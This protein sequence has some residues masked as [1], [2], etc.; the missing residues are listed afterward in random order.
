MPQQN[1]LPMLTA[2][3][4]R[5]TLKLAD[6]PRDWVTAASLA[7]AIGVSRRTVLREL[8]G[9][10]QWM[11]A[12]G[13]K[14]V[15]SPGQGIL[16]EESE[17]RRAELRR[18]AAAGS[19]G[20]ALPREERR[21]RLLCTLLAAEEP[22]K[23][24]A[25]AYDLQV[26]EHTLAADLAWAEEWLRPHGTALRRRPGVGVWVE[27]APQAKRRAVGAL[28][29][30]RLPEQNRRAFLRGEAPEEP[31]TALFDRQ[32]AAAVWAAL[33]EFEK[34]EKLEFTDAGFLSLAVHCVLTVEQLGAGRW[35]TESE[36]GLPD[37]QRPAA[38]QQAARLAQKL[39]RAFGV[40]IPPAEVRHLALYLDVY[41]GLSDPQEWGTA[42]E[43]EL[44]SLAAALIAGVEREMGVDLGRYPTL[45][46]DLY[47]HLRPMFYRVQQGAAVENPQL[48]LIQQQYAPLWR[49][50]RAA[51]DE[52]AG[53]LGLP[54]IPDAE[55][56][57]LAMHFGAVLEKESIARMRV[58]A[59]VV[60]PY[61]M[62]SSKFLASQLLREF[63]VLHITASC[64]ARELDPEA[65]RE[66][67]VDVV[68]STVP[69]E[70]EFPKVCVNPI[71]QEQDRAQLRR[72]VEQAQ[73]RPLRSGPQ[74]AAPEEGALRYAGRM[75][76]LLLELLDTLKIETA[77][78]PRSRAGLIA[79]GA[80]LFCPRTQDR[81]A[82]E[83]AF[84]RRETMGD[85]YIK[86][87]RALLLHCRTPAVRGCRLGYLR[88]DLPVYEQGK[89]MQGVLVLLAPPAGPGDPEDLPLQVMQAVS[90][91]LIE[92]PELIAALRAADRA[93]AAG[94]L[95]QGL[96]RQFRH[97]LDNRWRR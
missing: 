31:L 57:Y 29:R 91:L 64:S 79:A 30:V 6:L 50:T 1:D 8:P 43:M 80:A 67:G 24:Y 73:N 75:S 89:L 27:G 56:G 62:A 11:S 20:D 58:C 51:C 63:P 15:R 59:V 26:S 32:T 77:P 82:V 72:A 52:A 74:A 35:A 69:L 87:L 12:A 61:G 83:Q 76:A 7:E 28:L 2:N 92:Q 66:Q 9:V 13:F 3:G 48:E 37:G 45:A 36:G 84:L 54:H 19:A 18:L 10:E 96:A 14:L 55:A 88:A 86:P 40:A 21:Q 42:D 53:L 71:L 70:I 97:A 65:L 25:L 38:M 49:A 94:L 34:E 5:L 16:L 44:H 17:P 47:C 93:K 78:I 95:E 68:I 23:T 81:E 85:T 46:K 39:E 60:C 90:G 22:V 33:R 41:G 4:R